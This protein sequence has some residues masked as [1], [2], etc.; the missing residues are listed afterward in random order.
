M[1]F[2][3]TRGV[4]HTSVKDKL[5]YCENMPCVEIRKEGNQIIILDRGKGI[6]APGD[7]IIQSN[8]TQRLNILTIHYYRDHIQEIAS[9]I[10]VYQKESQVKFYW[11]SGSDQSIRNFL[12]DQTERD[13]FPVRTEDVA[14]DIKFEHN[15]PDKSFDIDDLDVKT[16]NVSH[17]SPKLNIKVKEKSTCIIYMTDNEL[18]AECENKRNI[19]EKIEEI[20]P[21]AKSRLNEQVCNKF[22]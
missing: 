7:I 11:I 9:I 12:S 13:Y 1:I 15:K 22:S 19:D 8:I 17:P 16:F 10:V 4:V 20:L 18:D 6:R 14:D 5:R 2:R 3:G 21:E